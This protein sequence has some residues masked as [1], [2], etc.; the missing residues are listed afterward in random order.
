MKPKLKH[1]VLVK[2]KPEIGDPKIAEVFNEILDASEIVPNVEDY[3]EGPEDGKQGLNQGY[4]HGFVMT[5]KDK[6][7]RDNYLMH[8]ENDRIKGLL[9]PLCESILVF[10]FE[11]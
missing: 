2:F 7:A 8:P 9:T 1:I 6:Y 4:T 11:V 5:F 3:V 10:D